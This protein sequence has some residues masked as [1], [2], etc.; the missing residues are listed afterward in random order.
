MRTRAPALFA[1]AIAGLVALSSGCGGGAQHV[2][3]LATAGIPVTSTPPGTI[4]LEVV[5]RGTAVPD[6][7]PVRGTPVVYGDL[8]AALGLAVSTA[9]VPWAQDH[10][11]KRP[12]GWQLFVELTRAE[13]EEHDGRLVVALDVR[14]TLSSRAGNVYLG[15]TSVHCRQAGVVD[16]ASGGPVVYA[17]MTRLG[18]DLTSWLSAVQP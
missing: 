13:A 16:A 18:R 12:D 1:F 2:G 7:L 10:R 5:T 3:L 9:G 11:A 6:P 14:A 4:P 8:E 15:Q 17:C